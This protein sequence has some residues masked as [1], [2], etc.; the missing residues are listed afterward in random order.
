MDLYELYNKYPT[1]DWDFAELL[2]NENSNIRLLSLFVEKINRAFELV[3]HETKFQFLN[4]LENHDFSKAD[5]VFYKY[6]Y[7]Y[8][9]RFSYTQNGLTFFKLKLQQLL[10]CTLQND[11]INFQLI[12]R[13]VKLP[14]DWPLICRTVKMNI[15]N[16]IA[17]FPELPLNYCDY[18]KNPG[19]TIEIVR[20]L[21]RSKKVLNWNSL[22]LN[23]SITA[24]EI[25]ENDD[26][27]WNYDIVIRKPY[28]SLKNVLKCKNYKNHLTQLYITDINFIIENKQYQ[29]NWNMPSS[30]VHVDDIFNHL[31]LPWNYVFVSTNP[32]LRLELVKSHLHLTWDWAYLSKNE[33]ITKHDIERNI[34]LPFKWENVSQNTNVDIAFVCKHI[35]RFSNGDCW[36]NLSENSGFLLDEV[37]R[38]VIVQ[39]TKIED[40]VEPPA[41]FTT[42]LEYTKIKNN[43]TTY[44]YVQDR[45]NNISFV[46][47]NSYVFDNENSISSNVKYLPWCFIYTQRN[48]KLSTSFDK[49]KINFINFYN[50]S[51]SAY[52]CNTLEYYEKREQS[53]IKMC[54]QIKEELLQITWH[55]DH[56]QRLC[57]SE[58]EQN[59]FKHKNEN[60]YL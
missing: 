3:E 37:Y 54:K 35:N 39:K 49:Q 22:T 31:E 41:E 44:W 2:R 18:C 14:W 12:I 15:L 30:T 26:L 60:V 7:F 8:F 21:H 4:F 57:L 5:V 52:R 16:V 10:N 50:I 11:N 42:C 59:I 55:P 43:D 24:D 53:T 45:I 46:S 19:V 1:E 47:Y 51:Q 58:A 36:S 33:A 6:V 9:D 13:F 25:F 32:T 29:L 38:Y 27:P 48:M 34:E 17:I 23:E 20:T 40:V 28:I 56:F